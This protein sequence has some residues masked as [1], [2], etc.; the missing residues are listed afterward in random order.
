MDD[1]AMPEALAEL[2]SS[3]VAAADLPGE[4]AYALASMF[5][6]YGDALQ[7][8]VT[9]AEQLTTE[10]PPPKLGKCCCQ[11]CVHDFFTHHTVAA[12][13]AFAKMTRLK[14]EVV[15]RD[16]TRKVPCAHK[17]KSKAR[18]C[19]IIVGSDGESSEE[20]GEVRNQ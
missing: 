3:S 6:E 4:D 11:N 19:P 20:E 10:S 16:L 8:C 18:M 7:E 13:E 17:G 12:K 1:G 2:L 9:S 14:A 15:K 5:G